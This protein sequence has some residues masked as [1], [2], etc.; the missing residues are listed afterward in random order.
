MLSEIVGKRVSY[1]PSLGPF[2]HLRKVYVKVSQSNWEVSRDSQG[3]REPKK[4]SKQGRKKFQKG[5]T[6]ICREKIGTGRRLCFKRL[7][8]NR[9]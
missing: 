5:Q 1:L 9:R 8:K 4:N 2:P 7:G 6:S 3:K